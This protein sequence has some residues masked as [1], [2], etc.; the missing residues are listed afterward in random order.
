MP[1]Q[2]EGFALQ[3]QSYWKEFSLQAITFLNAT[4]FD[5]VIKERQLSAPMPRKRLTS[6]QATSSNL[7]PRCNTSCALPKPDA[8][9]VIEHLYCTTLQMVADTVT[10]RQTTHTH[11]RYKHTRHCCHLVIKLRCGAAFGQD[12]C[13]KE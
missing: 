2:Q 7:C 5:L 9:K 6:S 10:Q 11:T 12:G 3:P 13:H 8:L 4:L 1:S